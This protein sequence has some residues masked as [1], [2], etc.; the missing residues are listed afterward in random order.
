MKLKS[1]F[2][3]Q[4]VSDSHILV[5]VGKASD[6]FHGIVRS[7]DTA[8]FIIECLKQETTEQEIVKKMLETYDVDSERAA[9][10][11]RMVIEKLKDVGAL[12]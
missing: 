8:G 5:P 9:T 11:V 7:N 6:N 3:S 2:I 10:G 1:D 4:I 12:E